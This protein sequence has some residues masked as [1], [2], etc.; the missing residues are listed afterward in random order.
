[1]Y[2]D[3]EELPITYQRPDGA[4]PTLRSPKHSAMSDSN[5]RKKKVEDAALYFKRVEKKITA[6]EANLS[7]Y[8]RS[9]QF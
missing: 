8:K 6:E 1:M 2:K 7:Q 4:Y 5:Q 3:R 9:L